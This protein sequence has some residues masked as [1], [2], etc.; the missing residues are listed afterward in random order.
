MRYFVACL[1]LMLC[2]LAHA[3]QNSDFIAA[4]EAYRT[5]QVQLLPGYAQ[6]LQNS[7]LLPYVQYWLL[8]SRLSVASPDEIRDYIAHNGDTPLSNKLRLAWLR[9]LGGQQ[10]W[11]TYLSEYPLAINPDIGLQCYDLQARI[12][13][14]ADAESAYQGGKALWFTGKTLPANCDDL[15]NL[16][17]A[18]KYL[19][20]EDVW[21][22]LRLT[23]EDNNIPAALALM[24]YLPDVRLDKHQL[25]IAENAPATLLATARPLKQRAEQELVLYAVYRLAQHDASAAATQWESWQ[26]SFPLTEQQ[27]V[28]GQ[29]AVFASR[30]HLTQALAWFDRADTAMLDD[31]ALGWKT[32]AALL[33]GDWTTVQDSILSMSDSGQAKPAWRYWLARA[34]KALGDTYKAN[35]LLIPLSR[36]Y[37]FYGLL[38]EEDLGPAIDNPSVNFQPPREQIQ[39]IAQI[40]AIRR[41]LRLFT[42]DFRGEA[43]AEWHW[44][45]RD[46][47][48]RRLLA[49][50]EIARRAGWLD[51]A[52]N[53]AN[54]TQQLH[55]FE[56]SFLAPYR[57]TAHIYAQEY[58]LDE[59][60]VYGLMRQESRFVSHA[61]SGV[62]ASGIMQLMPS[63]AYWIANRL[64]VHH[65]HLIELHKLDTNMQFGMY[66]LK[67]IEQSL[68]NSALLATAAYNAGPRRAQRWRGDHPIEGAIYAEAIPFSETRD[69]V[70]KVFANTIFYARS[71]NQHDTSIKTR[72][73]SVAPATPLA[74]TGANER[75]PSCDGSH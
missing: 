41:A 4:R 28:W 30:Q 51:N 57:D 55:N 34:D 20:A 10:D 6:R 42:M 26:K 19:N 43:Y 54:R 18:G 60:W 67:S 56:L 47:G 17:I 52:I 35:L 70:K 11:T 27:R 46:F 75:A 9:Q 71:F 22:R 64:G 59:A 8:S 21:Q 36:E 16:L 24:A 61:H 62:G 25:G 5:G 69:Y 58:G 3:D 49:A 39:A 63:T 53:T 32:R 15:F 38:A 14:G 40:P 37:S 23:L 33:S 1:L 29:I 44:A 50:A 13:Q 65:F 72:L 68:G 31:S 12:T 45:I 48:D 66:Y 7:V 2:G 74:C 73:G